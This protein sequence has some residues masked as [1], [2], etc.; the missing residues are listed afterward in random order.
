[1]AAQSAPEAKSAHA[2]P[3]SGL[4]LDRLKKTSEPNS[5]LHCGGLT[6]I[7]LAAAKSDKLGG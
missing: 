7:S 6:L 1:M 3:A 2:P 5:I 4:R